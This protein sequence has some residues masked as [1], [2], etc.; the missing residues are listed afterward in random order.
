MK[1]MECETEKM[2]EVK[3]KRKD[4]EERA[5]TVETEQVCDSVR[6]RKGKF[7][8]SEG[9]QQLLTATCWVEIGSVH[10]QTRKGRKGAKR[11]LF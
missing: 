2:K 9:Y 6:L 4:I 8:V 10:H 1:G 11:V 5:I 3:K 7:S